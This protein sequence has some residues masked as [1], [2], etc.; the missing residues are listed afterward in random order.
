M[1]RNSDPSD[2]E[3]S[4]DIELTAPQYQLVTTKKRFPAFVAG[5]GSGKTAAL[6][7]RCIYYKFRYPTL[8]VGY[9]LPHS[10]WCE[11]SHSRALPSALWQWA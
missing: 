10:A 1:I 4:F 6:I 5:F 3:Q 8:N 11:R 2:P 9:Y 7:E